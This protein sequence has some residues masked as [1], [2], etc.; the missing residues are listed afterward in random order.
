MQATVESSSVSTA[1][2]SR[3]AQVQA[4][5][6]NP[7][8]RSFLDNLSRSRFP[9]AV[10]LF[11]A[12]SALCA[13]LRL[14]QLNPTDVPFETWTSAAVK[15]WFRLSTPRPN[16]AFLGSSLMLSPLGAVD[17]D[18]LNRDIDGPSHHR[19]LYFEQAY[20][21]LTGES[22]RTF[23]FALPGEM[24]S[25]ACLIT[26]FLLKGEKRPN[27]LVYGLGPRDFLDNGLLSPGSTD[28]YQTLSRFGNSNN[29]IALIAPDWQ[30]RLNFEL[31]RLLHLYGRK[32]DLN[33]CFERQVSAIA[34][35]VVPA[36]PISI[37]QRR[38]LLP[39]YRITEVGV[40]DCWFGPSANKPRPPLLDN[41]DEYR[42]RYKNLKWDTYLTQMRFLADLL[43]TARERDVHVVVM[44]MPITDINRKL[45]S[46]Q[47]WDLYRHSLK[48]MAMA[49]GATYIDMQSSQAF[50]LSDFGDT[51]H[52]HSGGGAKLL[53]LLAQKLAGDRA[54][55]AALAAPSSPSLKTTTVA[56]LKGTS[57]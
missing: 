49:K 39:G 13:N 21:K 36:A 38:Q 4:P 55:T 31:G 2:A 56:G 22:V 57:L 33:T 29:R 52:L 32:V 6:G 35:Q 17:A 8:Q 25:D 20:K 50:Q 12:V 3:A 48:V 44:A 27:V 19:S 51:V 30:E 47:A 42:K 11:F 5:P 14:G 1:T 34:A 10:L 23:N 16:I 18:F 45:L 54:V 46:D 15:D 9:V 40:K 24:P 41:I 43:N 26:K 28:P 37:K 53:D 7:P